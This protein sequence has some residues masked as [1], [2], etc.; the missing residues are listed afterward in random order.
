MAYQVSGTSVIDDNKKLDNT[1]RILIP[2]GAAANR[3]SSPV[4]G[5]L[6]LNKLTGLG[7]NM[8]QNAHPTAPS[9]LTPPPVGGNRFQYNP[10]KFGSPQGMP[11]S[12]LASRAR[13]QMKTPFQYELEKLVRK[14]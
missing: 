9:F 3:P 1:T 14:V 4:T 10:Y 8:A 7:L 2:I 13:G 12:F 6:F 11:V 5:S